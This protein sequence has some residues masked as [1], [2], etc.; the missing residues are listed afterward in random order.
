MLE[1]EPP[2]VQPVALFVEW[3]STPIQRTVCVRPTGERPNDLEPFTTG[4]T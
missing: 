1:I 3:I 2:I 4:F